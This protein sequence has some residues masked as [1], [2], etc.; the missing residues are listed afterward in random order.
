[1]ILGYGVFTKKEIGKGDFICE[2]EG[3]HITGD[4]G[5]RR[6][7][8]EDASNGSFIYFFNHENKTFW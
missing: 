3:E 4:E 1:M 7:D 8:A 5:S 6:M 2:Y